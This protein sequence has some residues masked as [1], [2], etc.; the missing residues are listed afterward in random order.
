MVEAYLNRPD[1]FRA[2]GVR[3]V[4]TRVDERP[5]SWVVHYDSEAH[6]KSRRF[7]DAIAGNVPFVVLKA[8]GAFAPAGSAPRLPEAIAEVEARL[9]EG[10][11]CGVPS[12]FRIW[13]PPARGRE[14][15][16]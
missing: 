6:Q 11:D 9:A 10:T 1:A 14:N 15:Q 8:T 12:D 7:L 4:V 13:T 5:A 16:G 2:D 3:L